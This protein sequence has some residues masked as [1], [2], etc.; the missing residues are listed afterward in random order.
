MLAF[1]A[2]NDQIDPNSIAQIFV[3]HL[4]VPVLDFIWSVDL[5]IPWGIDQHPFI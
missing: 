3:A 5:A 1:D 2:K 4:P